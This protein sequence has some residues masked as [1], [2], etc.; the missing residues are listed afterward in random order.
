MA[1]IQELFE[2]DIKREIREVIK[3][4]QNES[5][6]LLNE[7]EEYIV[8]DSIRS[9]FGSILDAYAEVPNKPSDRMAVWVSG[10]FGSGKSSFAKLLGVA[11]ENRD[12]HGKSA[13]ELVAGRIADDRVHVLLR[14]IEQKMPTEVVMFDLATDTGVRN[15]NQKLTEI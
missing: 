5:A 13:A 4:D 10:F 3:V 6:V 11:V 9:S 2:R 15:A 12:L 1:M 7:I 14:K 8:T